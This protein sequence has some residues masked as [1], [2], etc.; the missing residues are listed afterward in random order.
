MP[1]IVTSNF[2]IRNAKQFLH[3]FEEPDNHGAAFPDGPSY[4]YL[5]IGKILSWDKTHAGYSDINAPV[6][7]SDV[8]GNS[9][10]PWRDM[11]AAA[12]VVANTDIMFGAKRTDWTTGTVYTQYD[13]QD[14]A[15]TKGTTDFFV[16]EPEGANVF[17]CLHN[18]SGAASTV[19]PTKPISAVIDQSFLT[20]DGYR[21]KYM[22]TIP[23]GNVTKFLTT[24]YF[25]VLT[26]NTLAV[27]PPSGYDDQASV[28]SN[29][30]NGTIDAYVVTAGGSGY[31]AHSGG[32]P[33]AKRK[34]DLLPVANTTFFQ[35]AADTITNA[36]PDDH[37]NGA[38]VFLSNTTQLKKGMSIIEDYGEL[39]DGDGNPYDRSILLQDALAVDMAPTADDTFV[40]GPAISIIGDGGRHGSGSHANAY[41]TCSSA[42]SI[43]AITSYNA[44]NNYSTANVT[45]TQPGNGT[46]SGANIRA[47]IAPPGG[48]G[49]DAVEELNGYNLI[50][51]KTLSG[52]GTG[53]TFPIS[54][55]YRTVGLVRNALL[56]NGYNAE[57]KDP[58]TAGANW[59][60]NTTPLHQSTWVR[61][62]TTF[63]Q[64][65]GWTPKEDYEVIG[66]T[67]GAKAR[68]IEYNM[69]GR[70]IINLVNV[71]ANNS[72]LGF[73]FNEQIGLLQDVSGTAGNPASQY[74]SA[75]GL[76]VGYIVD[77]EAPT[78]YAPEFV[79]FTGKILYIENRT[80]IAR[81]AEQ[82]ENISIVIEF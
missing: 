53:N 50:I 59:Y 8:Q 3:S 28:Q 30:N 13:D 31:T 48:H 9:F 70:G 12:R 62:N 55:K 33:E 49:S 51:A 41:S 15:V 74:V 24:N 23:G 82:L 61:A 34:V 81:S 40:I 79:E 77:T 4:V 78:I 19:K 68:V 6:P 43:S 29:A 21:W 18:N 20:S 5:F 75:N 38:A 26:I 67:S 32:I 42:G 54:N 1:A 69:D 60:A 71:V 27:S 17:K 56:A 66:N 10:E 65:G 80:P 57:V 47:I 2:R 39:T 44:G 72:G 63:L 36:F 73:M 58:A 46:G 22:F 25:P 7:D 35:L 64:A 45:A 52:S 16:Y 11:I 37:F 14:P 76:S